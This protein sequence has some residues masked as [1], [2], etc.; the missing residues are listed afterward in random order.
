MNNDRE[1][2][3]AAAEGAR[4]KVVGECALR[5]PTSEIASPPHP[6][7]GLDAATTLPEPLWSKSKLLPLVRLQFSNL[8]SVGKGPLKVTHTLLLYKSG[9]TAPS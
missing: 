4:G 2:S 3:M 8:Y 1:A 9:S 5:A 7:H 6:C